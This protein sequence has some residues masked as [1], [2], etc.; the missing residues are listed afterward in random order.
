MHQTPEPPDTLDKQ[1]PQPGATHRSYQIMGGMALLLGVIVA[2]GLLI[3]GEIGRFV[4]VGLNQYLFFIP[5]AM[6]GVLGLK[7]AWARLLSYSYAFSL[8]GMLIIITFSLA[9]VALVGVPLDQLSSEDVP[10]ATVLTLLLL[11]VTLLLLFVCCSAVLLVP[12]RVWLARWLSINPEDHTHTLALWIILFITTSGF[13]QLAFLGGQPPLLTAISSGAL[14]AEELAARS[15]LGQKLD[16]VYGLIWLLWLVLV[17]AGWPLKRPFGATLQRL[18]LVRPTLKQVLFGVGAAVAVVVLM[19][20]A[21][22]GLSTIWQWLGWQETD[23]DAFEQLLGATLSPLGA[24]VIGLTAGLGEELAV[25][26]LLQPRL[27]ILFSNL[28][29]TSFHAFQYGL[30]ALLIVFLLGNILG[31]IRARTNTTTAALVHGLYNTLIVLMSA[32]GF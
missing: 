24:L 11:L 22:Q 9:F 17:S 27:G 26:G 12:V 8:Q 13:V 30:D 25:R 16:L 3:G 31:I 4:E 21:G 1:P 6:L 10:R 18:G 29:F 23:V 5:L 7:Q 2:A 28:A 15:P 20:T 14:P 19:L 32:L